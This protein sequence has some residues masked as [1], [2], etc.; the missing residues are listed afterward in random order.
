MAEEET[1]MRSWVAYSLLAM[2]AWGSYIVVAKIATAEKYCGLSPRLSALL[3]YG[4]IGVAFMLYWLSASGQGRGLTPAS[5]VAGLSAGFLWG[6]GMIFSLRAIEAGADV[7]RLAPIY[8]C[9]TLVAVLLGILVLREIG[10]ASQILR[11]VSGSVLIVLGGI[12]VAY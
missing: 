3:M 8:N 9:N 11:V 7:A 4:G 12:L 5:T 10:D 1:H 2:L 6:L